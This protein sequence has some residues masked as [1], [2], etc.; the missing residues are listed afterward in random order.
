MIGWTTGGDGSWSC[1]NEGILILLL[2]LPPCAVGTTTTVSRGGIKYGADNTN[3]ELL[4]SLV[5]PV[6]S[7]LMIF[8]SMVLYGWLVV[9]LDGW[10]IELGNSLLAS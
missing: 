3:D 4:L 7:R 8:N 5:V 10:I 6:S 1:C 2:L 9:P